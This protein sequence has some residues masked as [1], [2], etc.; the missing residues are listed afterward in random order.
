MFSFFDTLNH[1]I[2]LCHKEVMNQKAKGYSNPFNIGSHK[3]LNFD[4]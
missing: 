3:I 2:Q 1:A 4:Y